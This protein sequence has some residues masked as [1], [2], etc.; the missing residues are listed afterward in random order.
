MKSRFDRNE[1]GGFRQIVFRGDRLQ[2]VI[3]QPIVQ[4]ANRRRISLEQVMCECIYL[5]LSQF[6]RHPLMRSA[7]RAARMITVCAVI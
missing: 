6:H 3:R 7:L 2:Q 4:R 1:E 5:K